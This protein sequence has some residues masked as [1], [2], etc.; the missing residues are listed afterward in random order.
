MMYKS[1]ETDP[2]ARYKGLSNEQLQSI[3]D[4][5][6]RLLQG[7]AHEPADFYKLKKENETLKN[8]LE[9][10]QSTGFGTIM[11][12]FSDQ[13]NKLS[14]VGGGGGGNQISGVGL[15]QDQLSNLIQ[16]NKQLKDMVTS[17]LNKGVMVNNNTNV[18]NITI[19]GGDHGRVINTG[20][21]RQPQPGEPG[22]NGEINSGIS[23]KFSNTEIP[24][25]DKDGKIGISASNI[26]EH[27]QLQL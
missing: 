5:V 9:T 2:R 14:A 15:G 16:D 3:D 26:H 18:H 4:Y 6:I 25:H 12:N 1:N 21:F 19:D 10:L 27:A 11:R 22:F 13:L 17:L 24:L 7:S 8:Q 20:Q 23:Y